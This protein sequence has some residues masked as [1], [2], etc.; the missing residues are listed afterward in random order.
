MGRILI[1]LAAVALALLFRSEAAAY[2]AAAAQ[3]P[4]LVG[5]LV[6]VLAVLAIGQEVVRRRRVA[7]TAP[8]VT[9]P[10]RRAVT[11]GGGFIALIVAY[12]YAVPHVGYLVAT[13]VFL[14][15]PMAALRPASWPVIAL[16]IV[17]VMGV[18]WGVFVGFLGLPIPFMPGG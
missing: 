9:L 5:I 17:V 3:L 18:I 10:T 6:M 14:L 2:P 7:G 1:A 4:N 11:I 16:T 15:A 12:V 8:L 13:V